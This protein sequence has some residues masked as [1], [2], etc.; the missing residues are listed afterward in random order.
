VTIKNGEAFLTRDAVT[1]LLNTHLNSGKVKDLSVETQPNKV[2]IKGKAHKLVDVPFHIDGRVVATSDGM[3]KLQVGDEHA[4]HLPDSI[5]KAL[6]FDDLSKMIPNNGKG[7]KAS[8]NAVIFDPDLMW[9]L[10]IHGRVVKATTTAKGLE[11]T[12][13]PDKKGGSSAAR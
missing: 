1:K 3:I 9:G 13:G 12:F 5:T 2:T 8:K 7:V 6:G 11:L 4:A 10:P